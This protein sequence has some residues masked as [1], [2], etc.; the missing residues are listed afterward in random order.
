MP[1]QPRHHAGTPSGGRFAVTQRPEPE[2]ELGPI[3]NV[4]APLEAAST[5]DATALWEYVR[6]PSMDVRCEAA[7]NPSITREQL[8][9]LTRDPE[10]IVRLEIANL[11]YSGLADKMA[12]DPNAII[13]H[14]AMTEGWDLS[15]TA[16]AA[17]QHDEAVQ[18][19]HK[20]VTAA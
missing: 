19:V 20:A 12:T 5:A 3:D 1:E 15:D 14:T 7:T 8:D 16:L 10:W 9:E 18:R 13:R 11:P 2:A 4:R 6:H 17:L